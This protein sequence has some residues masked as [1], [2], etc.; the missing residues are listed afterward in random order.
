M[1]LREFEVFLGTPKLIC[2]TFET[3][4]VL[5]KRIFKGERVEQEC[6]MVKKMKNIQNYRKF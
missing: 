1:H 3:S 2:A 6:H 5:Q 4:L